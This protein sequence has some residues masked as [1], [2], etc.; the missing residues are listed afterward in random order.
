MAPWGCCDP[1]LWPSFSSSDIFL[2]CICN[3]NR[4]LA[5]VVSSRFASTRTAPAVELLSLISCRSLVV[6]LTLVTRLINAK[7]FASAFRPVSVYHKFVVLSVFRS[8]CIASFVKHF[9]HFGLTIYCSYTSFD[10]FVRLTILLRRNVS[11]LLIYSS[12]RHCSASYGQQPST[13][14]SCRLCQR[15]TVHLCSAAEHEVIQFL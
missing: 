9:W 1:S 2:L 12:S 15:T 14:W 4:A 6:K 7:Q 3:K 13:G 10:L 5:L 8:P 11:L